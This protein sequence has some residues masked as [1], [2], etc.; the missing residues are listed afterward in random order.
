M[1]TDERL[2]E[3][4]HR[5]SVMLSALERLLV[6]V[7]RLHGDIEAVASDLDDLIGVIDDDADPEPVEERRYRFERVGDDARVRLVRVRS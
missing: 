6:V 7:E 2:D 5:A 1:T 3:L 4:E